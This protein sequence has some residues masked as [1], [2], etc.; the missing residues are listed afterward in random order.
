MSLDRAF[1]LSTLILTAIA[2]AGLAM[3]APLAAGFLALGIASL[4]LSAIERFYRPGLLGMSSLSTR[5]WNI[6]I[7]V[8]F[9]WF[10][11]DFLWFSRDLL[12]A[13]VH[14]LIALMVTK[15]FNLH[16][17]RDYL[18]LYAI[19]LMMVL[20]SA[21]M[22]TDL[23]YGTIVVAFLLTGV[24][25][26]LL[27]QL[28]ME[29]TTPTQSLDALESPPAASLVNTSTAR[30]VDAS[31]F[32]T[33][34]G[35]AALA[36]GITL[37]IF[38]SIP[39]IGTGYF[40]K[41]R[42]DGLRTAGFSERVDLGAMGSIKLDDSVVMRVELPA[43]TS[44]L[45]EPLYLRGMAYDWYNGRSWTNNARR[46]RLSAD[47]AT[48]LFTLP[49]R[50]R[51]EGVTLLAH[52]ILL[53][54]L[55][56]P[57]LFGASLPRAIEGEFQSLQ[58]DAMAGLYLT[59][60]PS[61][62]IH[63]R[64]WSAATH[65]PQASPSTEPATYPAEIRN[66]F[67][68]L[69]EDNPQIRH[70]AEA[71]TEQATTPHEKVDALYAVLQADY[72][73]SLDVG[74]AVSDRPLEDFLFRRKTGYCEHYAS[75]LVV[76]LR[77]V[78]V[79]ARLVTGFLASEWN[80]YGHYYT[81]RQRDAHAWV[82]VY[83]PAAGWIT[84]DPTPSEPPAAAR[85]QW[86]SWGSLWDSLRLQ[87]DRVIVQYSATDQ[88]AVV[89]TL[90]DSTDSARSGLSRIWAS[91]L[92]QLS[93][94][95]DSAWAMASHSV[96][97]IPLAMLIAAALGWGGFQLLRLVRRLGLWRARFG[98]SGQGA[99]QPA[100]QS[101]ETRAAQQLYG[102]VL[103]IL[104]TKGFTKSPASTPQEFVQTVGETWQDATQTLTRIT[105]LYYHARFN[106]QL[107][108]PD[109]GAAANEL[110]T[111]LRRLPPPTSIAQRSL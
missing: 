103:S 36:L 75:A 18:Q 23:W 20:A 4:A 68:V 43:H 58:T 62:R 39:R 35:F 73:Y 67:L 11:I 86:N 76:L 1:Q 64:V 66:H 21:G 102:K 15:L 46:R 33:T 108:S 110:L 16:Q 27:Y 93:M 89:Q 10:W 25:T 101:E 2:L 95:A 26:L 14:F 98:G 111:T 48:H 45:A 49:A 8:A 22:T 13:G 77:S 56:T 70:F 92:Q 107:L 91:V 63:Y 69:P 7:L 51:Q 87:W 9:G 72:R 5:I 40:H 24:W 100:A 17:R 80:D 19:D 104:E 38:F 65:W 6:A 85:S 59:V 34:N 30:V 90:R 60:P 54:S 50:H 61:G 79:P 88:M 109:D 96:L 81:V 82:E 84:V 31:F 28:R 99:H 42:A 71:I 83:D 47:P 29:G 78:G 105:Q 41:G 74:R 32:W 52:D 44:K 3:T 106:A 12:S 55:D 57:V 37:I 53:E 97:A 94:S